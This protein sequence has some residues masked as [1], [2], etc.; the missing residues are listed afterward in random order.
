MSDIKTE[1]PFRLGTKVTFTKLLARHK[2]NHAIDRMHP[3]SKKL[4]LPRIGGYYTYPA[5]WVENVFSEAPTDGVIVGRKTLSDGYTVHDR[6]D[7]NQYYPMRHFMAWEVAY[8]LHRKPVLVLW[9]QRVWEF[10]QLP[11]V[12]YETVVDLNWEDD[13]PNA[14]PKLKRRPKPEPWEEFEDPEMLKQAMATFAKV[15]SPEGFR[16]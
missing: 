14:Q 15:N 16:L 13:G 5:Y 4:I 1:L 8:S 12:E 3:E 10:V 2:D 7:G 9:P 6:D 11:P